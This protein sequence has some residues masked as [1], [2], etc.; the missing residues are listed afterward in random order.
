M[1]DKSLFFLSFKIPSKINGFQMKK[2]AISVLILISDIALAEVFSIRAACSI[3]KGILIDGYCMWVGVE[4]DGWKPPIARV[5]LEPGKNSSLRGIWEQKAQIDSNLE[6][7]CRVDIR[8]QLEAKGE[9]VLTIVITSSLE[10]NRFTIEIPRDDVAIQR[11]KVIAKL[12]DCHR[13]TL[14]IQSVN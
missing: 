10:M 2:L 9:Y 8:K 13:A 5:E 3:A 1:S 6:A 11:S 7:N 14:T 12:P 4:E